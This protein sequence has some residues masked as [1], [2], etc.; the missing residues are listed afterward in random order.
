MM[1]HGPG[2]AVKTLG[3]AMVR[4][5]M[6]SPVL[7]LGVLSRNAVSPKLSSCVNAPSAPMTSNQ[8]K[9]RMIPAQLHFRG[10]NCLQRAYPHFMTASMGLNFFSSMNII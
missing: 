4:K 2:N 10:R 5:V 7:I 1:E 3:S 6:M 8:W 9:V